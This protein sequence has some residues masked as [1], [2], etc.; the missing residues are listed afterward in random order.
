MVETDSWAQRRTGEF[1][2]TEATVCCYVMLFRPKAGFSYQFSSA[3]VGRIVS[4]NRGISMS[5]NFGVSDFGVH[6][7]FLK[8][9]TMHRIRDA[10]S[11][12][13]VAKG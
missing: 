12:N 7:N 11:V 9:E 13:M 4:I 6:G 2:E 5:A 3:A 10:S 8:S 1:L